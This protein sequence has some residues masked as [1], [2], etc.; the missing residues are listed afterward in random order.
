[1]SG[2][3][4]LAVWSIEEITE[5]ASRTFSNNVIVPHL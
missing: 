5:A 4:P 2:T 3:T 1:M